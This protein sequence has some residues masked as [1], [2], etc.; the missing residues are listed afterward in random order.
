ME[1]AYAERWARVYFRDF[2]GAVSRLVRMREKLGR[3]I[4]ALRDRYRRRFGRSGL[5]LYLKG[6]S[7]AG[8]PSGLYWGR[9]VRP[10]RRGAGPRGKARWVVHLGRRLE[11]AWVY[12]IARDAANL[13]LYRAFDREA[14][15][16]NLRVRAAA[17]AFRSVAGALRFWG[18]PDPEEDAY[19]APPAD[20]VCEMTS[21][22]PGS[23]VLG[24]WRLAVKMVRT[25]L[26]LL[27]LSRLHDASPPDGRL[28]LVFSRDRKNPYGRL[29]WRD[30]RAGLRHGALT[31]R[32]LRRLGVPSFLRREVMRFEA[33]RRLLSRARRRYAMVFRRCKLAVWRALASQPGTA[34]VRPAPVR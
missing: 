7:G 28:R 30:A 9:L 24:G 3:E 13:A 23:I 25:E 11:D 22:L 5:V 14:A 6:R 34:P 29:I 8:A 1:E 27:A 31:I 33:E 16:L 19:P 2:L 20:L 26:A 4:L 18:R 15:G 10:W 12:G 21:R 32:S 17:D